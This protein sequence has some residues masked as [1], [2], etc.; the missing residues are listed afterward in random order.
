MDFIKKHPMIWFWLPALFF[1]YILVAWFSIIYF[2]VSL[3]LTTLFGMSGYVTIASIHSILL[4]LSLISI[5]FNTSWLIKILSGMLTSYYF[6]TLL[7]PF[8]I[9][10]FG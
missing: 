6:L 1:I 9:I 5:I 4:I 8:S 3:S 7:K 10:F 2:E